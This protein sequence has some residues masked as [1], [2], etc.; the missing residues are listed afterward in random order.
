MKL[1]YLSAAVVTALATTLTACGGSDD[2]NDVSYTSTTTTPTT[3]TPAPTLSSTG[4]TATSST[5][6]TVVQSGGEGTGG[7][8]ANPIVQGIDTS[9][10]SSVVGQS[11][12]RNAKANFD[13]VANTNATNK[14]MPVVLDATTLQDKDMKNII[15]GSEVYSN[16]TDISGNTVKVAVN[17]YAGKVSGDDNISGVYGTKAYD[18]TTKDFTKDGSIDVN[19]TPLQQRNAISIIAPTTYFAAKPA[20]TAGLFYQT[21][22]STSTGAGGSADMSVQETN[23]DTTNARI[24]GSKAFDKDGVYTNKATANSY[25]AVGTVDAKTG[26]MT[27]ATNAKF[28]NIKLDNVQYGRVSNNVDALSAATIGSQIQTGQKIVGTVDRP[29]NADDAVNT[30]YYRGINESTLAQ[31]GAIDQKGVFNYYGHALTY[32]VNGGAAANSSLNSNSVGDTQNVTTLGD[33]VKATYDVANKKVTGD[34]YNV[35]SVN[36]AAGV[37]NPLIKFSGTVTG[38]TVVGTSALATD[39]ANTGALKA[40]FYGDQ[41][42]ELGGA[43]NSINVDKYGTSNWGGVFG[44]KRD[45]VQPVSTDGNIA[46]IAI[47]P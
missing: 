36:G 15:L 21:A 11:Y 17:R 30:Y 44:A 29:F 25:R 40:S 7:L 46:N 47:K 16:A 32:G 13:Y 41:A 6:T 33:F 3:T 18:E 38:N 19:N 34:I 10:V 24:F 35:K 1:N 28:D 26:L 43:V 27:Y 39:A 2:N 42:Q 20:D 22:T 5:G 9:K 12:N 45:I 23:K 37:E 4:T 14:S 8:V 31:M